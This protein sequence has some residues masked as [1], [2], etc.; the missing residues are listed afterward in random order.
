MP[1]PAS[2]LP[3]ISLDVP[4]RTDREKFGGLFYL[5]VVGLIVLVL[6]L[7][8]FGYG[9]WTMRDVW[10]ATY[11]LHDPKRSDTERILAAYDLTRDAHVTQ[12]QFWDMC[13]EK[14]L[15][16]LARYILAERLSV[17]AVEADPKAYA[18]AVAYS[19]GWPDWLRVLLVR[20]MA[21]APEVRIV[22]PQEPLVALS[23]HSDPTVRLWSFY[24]RAASAHDA[25][26][27]QALAR[28]AESEEPT[29]VLAQDLTR[30]LHS[31]ASERLQF[32]VEATMWLRT[33]HPQAA[34]LWHGWEIREGQLVSVSP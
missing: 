26:A 11:I 27:E 33:H 5:G 24:V 7:A 30:A 31:V 3:I 13:L 18:E 14:S 8:W 1:P 9:V 32:L 2:D 4:A 12:R 34:E 25:N 23:N 6:L 21:F 15:P 19:E 28:Q 16:S 29:Q 17:E 20:P 10:R 22:F